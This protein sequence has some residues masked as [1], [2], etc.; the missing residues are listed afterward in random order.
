MPKPPGAE[1]SF[2]PRRR[3]NIILNVTLSSLVVLAVVVMANYLGRDYFTR[4][5]WGAQGKA[6]LS[7]LTINFLRSLTNQVKVTLFYNKKDPLYGIVAGLLDEYH[8]ANP[9]ISVQAVDWMLNPD[10]AQIV[11]AEYNLGL[12]A[13]DLIL[14]DCPATG[15][16]LP[17]DGQQLTWGV[18]NLVPVEPET[19]TET[20]HGRIAFKLLRRPTEF[21]GERAF[22]SAILAVTSPKKLYAYFL[23][24]H[25]GEHEIEDGTD[26]GYRTFKSILEQNSIHAES[27][28]LMGPNT[29]PTNCNLLVTA[30]PTQLFTPLELLKIDRYLDQGGR[31]LALF[32][33]DPRLMDPRTH[34]VPPCGLEVLL[35]KWGVDVGRGVIVDTN[36][37]AGGGGAFISVSGFSQTHPVV[38]PLISE[39][40]LMILPRKVGVLKTR[41]QSADAPHV[42]ELA[43]TGRDSFS[44]DQPG[45]PQSYPVMVA[46]ENTIRGVSTERSSTRIVVVGDSL[47]LAN[48]YLDEPAR[49]FTGYAVNWLLDRLQL[50]HGIGP[51]PIGQYR[52]VMTKVQMQATRWLL[53]AGMPG[54]VLFLGALVWLRR[55][56]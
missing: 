15:H 12:G 4:S 50:L 10:L 29:V 20:V 39:S 18:T 37:S 45:R 51:R 52:I 44:G 54:T 32:K 36:N 24:D 41:L 53:L 42:E 56:R 3:R 48:G 40:L 27:L 28:S 25:R 46:V 14:F 6:E 17:F 13:K 22:T 7:P 5:Y 31:L 49:A 8:L 21:L 55:R 38:N 33:F 1:P 2:S 23:E 26:L 11:R 30:G 16:R 43:F 19:E 47:F 35:E 34:L 9:R